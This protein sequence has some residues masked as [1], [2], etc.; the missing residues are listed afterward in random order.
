M[1]AILILKAFA[2]IPIPSPLPLP[3]FLIIRFIFYLLL[4]PFQLLGFEIFS[5]NNLFFSFLLFLI[6]YASV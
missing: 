1:A 4:F 3:F 5:S 6:R 2:R